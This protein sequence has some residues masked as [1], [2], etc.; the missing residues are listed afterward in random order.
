MNS[1]S[2]G[3]L[4]GY[5]FAVLVL[6]WQS[7]FTLLIET[8]SN[9]TKLVAQTSD[10][11]SKIN[12]SVS[13]R[14]NRVL[15]FASKCFDVTGHAHLGISCPVHYV[16]ETALAFTALSRRN[17]CSFAE[18]DCILQ[19]GSVQQCDAKRT[20]S[21]TATFDVTRRGAGALE[22]EEGSMMFMQVEF[23]CVAGAC[24]P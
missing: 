2:C 22:C 13:N 16:I 23:F 14:D 6:V 1:L 10:S 20:C 11:R 12:A 18:W 8:S 9:I 7:Y 15:F 4:G 21:V 3:M 19:E 17:V 24:Q 5:S